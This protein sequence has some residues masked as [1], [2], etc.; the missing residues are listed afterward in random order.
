PDSSH[1][2]I[3]GCF[4]LSGKLN[5]AVLEQSIHTII[6]RHEILRTIFI[7][8]EGKPAQHIVT[9]TSTPFLVI[10]VTALPAVE[11]A[12]AAQRLVWEEEQRAFQLDQGPLLRA[13]LLRLGTNEYLLCLTMHHIV[14]DAWSTGIFFRE[15]AAAYNAGLHGRAPALPALPIQYADFALWQ[16]D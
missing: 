4:H 10:D 14:S 5:V 3:A 8:D 7:E 15:L 16:R 1:Y 9:D 12:I 6:Q 2:I 13:R 11:R